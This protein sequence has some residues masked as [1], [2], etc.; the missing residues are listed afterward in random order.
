MEATVKY[1]SHLVNH[2]NE[3]GLDAGDSIK[4]FHKTVLFYDISF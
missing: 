3:K 4:A 2:L 1:I